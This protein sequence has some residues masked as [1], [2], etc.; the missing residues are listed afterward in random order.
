VRAIRQQVSSA[1]D[2][3]VHLTR[4]RD[5]TRR[6]TQVT[7]VEG[8]EGDQ[9]VMQD[10]AYFDYS[11]GLDADGKYLGRLKFTGIRPKFSAQLEQMGIDLLPDLFE[12]EP[13]E[14]G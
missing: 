4:L 6:I 9:I 12:Y 1:V 10:L 3:I 2:L 8:M 14:S 5:G 13:P 11:A 7:E